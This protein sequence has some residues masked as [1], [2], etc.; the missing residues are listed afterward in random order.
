MIQIR[1]TLIPFYPHGPVTGIE[2]S[3]CVRTKERSEG[4]LTF[5]MVLID[6]AV[7]RRLFG[8]IDGGMD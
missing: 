7:R 5:N 8:G 2:S 6:V 1:M 4:G 3:G